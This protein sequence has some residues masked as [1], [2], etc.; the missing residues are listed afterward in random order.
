MNRVERERKAYDEDR[1]F[2]VSDG[3][4]RR[5]PHVFGCAN[6]QSAERQFDAWLA[7]YGRG[8]TALELGCGDGG[9]A[10]RVLELGARSVRGLDVF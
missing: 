6:T 9:G 5:F 4:H 7:A 3:W 8:R 10:Q 1:V 2:E